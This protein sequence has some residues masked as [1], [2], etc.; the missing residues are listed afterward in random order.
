MTYIFYGVLKSSSA[1]IAEKFLLV[2][3]KLKRGIMLNRKIS[4]NN[5]LKAGILNA[6][7]PFPALTIHSENG[8]SKKLRGSS[9]ITIP[10]TYVIHFHLQA[11][12]FI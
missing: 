5:I 10:L 2:G 6:K 9:L 12:A 8:L 11:C 7:C 3:I 1:K 4:E